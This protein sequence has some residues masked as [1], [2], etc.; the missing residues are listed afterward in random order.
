[1]EGTDIDVVET[2]DAQGNTT[3]ET[4][5]ITDEYAIEKLK[6]DGIDN[7]T[8]EQI[9]IKQAELVTEGKDA[10]AEMKTKDELA[11]QDSDSVK[12]EVYE[13]T[14]DN[15]DKITVNVVH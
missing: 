3:T 13:T 2:T 14:A 6:E 9:A 7:P 4:V 12:R 11:T 10:I 5:V 1:M 8:N 15:G